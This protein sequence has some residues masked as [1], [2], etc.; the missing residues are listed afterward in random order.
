MGEKEKFNGRNIDENPDWLAEVPEQR[1]RIRVGVKAIAI[2]VITTGVIMGVAICILIGWSTNLLSGLC[3]NDIIS[4]QKQPEGVYKLVVFRR[5]CGATTGYSY[6]LSIMKGNQQIENSSGN[7]F[8]SKEEFSAYWD[9]SNKIFVNS[10]FKEFK[11]ETSYKGI[12][13]KYK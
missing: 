10:F 8:V 7:I 13:I 3:G 11:R 4:E 6:H 5:D 2:A 12:Q 9:H 1:I